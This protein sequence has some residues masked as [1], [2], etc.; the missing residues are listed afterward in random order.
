MFEGLTDE[1]V[2]RAEAAELA[3][4]DTRTIDR[5]ANEG[6][7]YR[8]KVGNRQWV[9]FRKVEIEAQ[10]RV[11]PVG[12]RPELSDNIAVRDGGVVSLKAD[13]FAE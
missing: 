11:V 12:R 2:T 7:I 8:H 10:I 6:R 13:P 5:W 1:F 4:V 3:G 9:R